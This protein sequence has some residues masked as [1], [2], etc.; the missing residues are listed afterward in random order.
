MISEAPNLNF[1]EGFRGV[2]LPASTSS[3]PPR[4]ADM[5]RPRK[6]RRVL[7]RINLDFLQILQFKLFKICPVRVLQLLA[8]DFNLH[9]QAGKVNI[10]DNF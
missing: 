3:R 6:S 4:K 9:G 7:I 8:G 1:F 2:E 5:E 10:L